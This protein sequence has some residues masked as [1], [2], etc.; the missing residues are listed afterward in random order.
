MSGNP[1]EIAPAV[2]MTVTSCLLSS[3]FN[4]KKNMGLTARSSHPYQLAREADVPPKGLKDLQSWQYCSNANQ[5]CLNALKF[6]K[7][8]FVIF[9]TAFLDE[10]D[11]YIHTFEFNAWIFALLKIYDNKF[12]TQDTYT[13]DVNLKSL[14]KIVEDFITLLSFPHLQNY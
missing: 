14:T 13:L 10:V 5:D 6:D 4:Y 3:K 8:N 11:N 9:F 2:L 12:R 7:H 1:T